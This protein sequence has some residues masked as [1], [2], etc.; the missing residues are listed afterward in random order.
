M[1]S[2]CAFDMLLFHPRS[3][4]LASVPNNAAR[5]GLMGRAMGITCVGIIYCP[6]GKQSG[7]HIN[8][9]ITLTFL[10]L[11]K[12]SPWDAAFYAL[13]QTAGGL[14]GVLLMAALFGRF[15]ADPVV[16]YVVTVPGP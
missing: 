3:P 11:G 10:R 16:E 1:V 9:S 4:M 12:I 13:F 2:A 7:A 5:L 8:P 6:W 14:A 15:L